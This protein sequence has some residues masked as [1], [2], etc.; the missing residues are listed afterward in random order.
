MTIPA[1]GFLE[2]LIDLPALPEWTAPA[3]PSPP[4]PLT[5]T[6]RP[7]AAPA[8]SDARSKKA[9]PRAAAGGSGVRVIDSSLA[10]ITRKP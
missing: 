5:K 4:T 2:P 6:N 10:S 8:G 3:E 1:A 9:K 7:A